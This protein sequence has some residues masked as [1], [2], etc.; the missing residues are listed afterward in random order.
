MS[1]WLFD[2][3]GKRIKDLGIPEEESFEKELDEKIIEHRT[4]KPEKI[5]SEKYVVQVPTN[6]SRD[7]LWDLKLFLQKQKTGNCQVFVS[8]WGK[9]AY[10]KINIDDESV[11]KEWEK[12]QWA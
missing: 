6:A 7:D 9:E 11:V 4:E 12:S 8:I 5:M 10:T 2:A 3:N 1:L